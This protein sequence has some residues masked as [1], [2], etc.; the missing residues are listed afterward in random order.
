VGVRWQRH[1][2]AVIQSPRWKRLRVEILRRDDF[3]CVQ[4]GKRGRLEIDHIRPVRDAP[5]LAYAPENLQTLCVSC[6]AAKTRAEVF[7]EPENPEK[8]K[9]RILVRS[10]LPDF[11]KP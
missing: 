4:C 5:E 1:S 9:W 2:Q 8:R 11:N 10:G 6:H 3:A 7:G